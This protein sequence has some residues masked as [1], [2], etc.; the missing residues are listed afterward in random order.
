M[1]EARLFPQFFF[2]IYI[3]FADYV[4]PKGCF[5]VPF[6]SAVHLNEN[7]YEDALTFNPWRWMIPENQVSLSKT[8]GLKSRCYLYKILK[9]KFK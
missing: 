4:I 1:E 2:S 8:H 6:L 9:I 5:I 7:I 3:V